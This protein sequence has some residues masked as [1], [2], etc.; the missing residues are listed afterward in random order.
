MKISKGDQTLNRKVVSGLTVILLIIL[1]G[2][3]FIFSQSTRG[4]VQAQEETMALVELDHTIEDV[5]NFYWVTFDET[6]FTLDFTDDQGQQIYAIVTQDGGD[7]HYYTSQDI[8]SHQD[9][10][11]ITL[12]ENNPAKLLQPRLGMLNNQPVWEIS[13]KTEEDTLSYFYID[14]RNGEWIQTIANV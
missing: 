7:I 14:A 6:F 12:S 2:L 1:V 4:M 3:L 9:A 11:S 8:I 13:F 10:L 5:N